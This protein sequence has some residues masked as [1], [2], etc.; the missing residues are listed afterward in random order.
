MTFDGQ[1]A[2]RSSS[3]Y[4][5]RSLQHERRMLSE[6]RRGAVQDAALLQPLAN[7]CWRAAAFEWQL[8]A[9][10]DTV[11]RLWGEAAHALAQ[12]F[13]RRRP[14]FDPSPD[15]FTLALHFA[16]AAREREVFTSLALTDPEARGRVLR[17][18][19]AFRGSRAHLHLAEGYAQV[20]RALVERA[21]APARAAVELLAAALAESDHGWWHQ[22]FPTALDAAWRISEH[23]ALCVLL[24]AVARRL[25]Q[26]Y[27][28]EP[29]DV[30]GWNDEAAAQFERVVDET[31]LRLEQFIE[32]DPNHHPKLYLWLPGLALCALAASAGL[33]MDWLSARHEEDTGTS[34]ARLPLALLR[35][36]AS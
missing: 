21:A 4:D 26:A 10:A 8:Y 32:H 35:N 18:A 11:R 5:L 22:Q 15:Q 7:A 17:E 31:L 1:S 27:A 16:I 20:A 29:E 6:Y 28:D 30:R 13:T 19:R 3:D 36:P 34:Y 23:E 24:G 14:G 2:A 25:A 12:G 33:P 9:D